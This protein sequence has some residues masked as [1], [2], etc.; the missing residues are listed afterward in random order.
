[1]HID[2][3]INFNLNPSDDGESSSGGYYY[4]PLEQPFNLTTAEVVAQRRTLKLIPA[5]MDRLANDGL[6]VNDIIKAYQL[7]RDNHTSQKG[8]RR[9]PSD[10]G[11]ELIIALY[12]KI[13]DYRDDVMQTSDYG[14]YPSE[15]VYDL[16][17]AMVGI[18]YMYDEYCA[19][20]RDL[21][22]PRRPQP[23]SPASSPTTMPNESAVPTK[24]ISDDAVE[25]EEDAAHLGQ[26]TDF[27]HMRSFTPNTD[28]D[29]S[30]LYT[31][32]IQEGVIVNIDEGLFIDCISHAHV[33]ELWEIAGKY[34]KR[35]LLQCL[36][37]MLTQEWY[38]REWIY[39][40]A[41]NMNTTVK[42][43]TN[44]TTSGATES[45]EDKLRRVLKPKKGA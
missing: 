23:E 28:F 24:P 2:E 14:P 29:M 6:D 21:I 15:A 41:S 8:K 33:N 17:C 45:F 19:A 13:A 40:C 4:I 22:V 37:K 32:L 42:N 26:T 38:P 43:L 18:I 35:N 20:I 9:V 5:L 10:K 11:R 25:A 36:F 31:F 3:D 34:R 27:T 1:M 30:A 7:V 12:D 44:P 39:K 16:R